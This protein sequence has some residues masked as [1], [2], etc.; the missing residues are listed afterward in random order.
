MKKILLVDDQ[1]T[2]VALMS[3]FLSSE[4]Y[5]VTTHTDGLTALQQMIALRPDLVITDLSMPGMDGGALLTAMRENAYLHE[6]PVLVL[7]GRPEH[8]MLEACGE[9]AVLMRKP[10]NP[11]DVLTSVRRLTQAAQTLSPARATSGRLT[12][13]LSRL[14]GTGQECRAHAA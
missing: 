1:P 8:E 14:G 12:A 11:D 7:S 3:E 10:A 6:T 9:R 2:L 4:G 5:D 13:S